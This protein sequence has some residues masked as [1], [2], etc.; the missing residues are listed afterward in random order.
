M[1]QRKS[2]FVPCAKRAK[3]SQP[4]GKKKKNWW[5]LR[6]FEP[7]W[8]NNVSM[9]SI[10]CSP[11]LVRMRLSGLIWVQALR[12]LSRLFHLH[13]RLPR[14]RRRPQMTVLPPPR[15]HPLRT[16]AANARN[17]RMPSLSLPRLLLLECLSWIEVAHC[18][19]ALCQVWM[20]R[21]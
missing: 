2:A 14:L 8:S 13:R 15:H 4:V 9:A 1:L 17:H 21:L 16:P 19:L 3:R 20:A 10:V 11:S 7:T 12:P 6:E 18:C 5:L